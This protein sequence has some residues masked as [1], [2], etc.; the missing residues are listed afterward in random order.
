[1]HQKNI[2]LLAARLIQL[3]CKPMVSTQ[4]AAH[5]CFGM[6]QFD[7][8]HI[9]NFGEVCC[10]VL[11]HC[12]KGDEGKYDAVYYTALLKKR[13]AIPEELEVLDRQMAQIDW[14][15]IIAARMDGMGATLEEMVLAASFMDQLF[16]V[17]TNGILRYRYWNGTILESMIPDITIIK[18]QYELQQRF[19]LTPDQE[20]IRFEE[21]YRFLQ[22]RWMEKRILTERKLLLKKERHSDSAGSSKKLLVKR[23][24][25]HRT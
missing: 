7:L 14:P 23:K 21:A 2:E 20:P 19:Y 22:S 5:A 8:T 15:K 11:I 6:P 3:G 4:L 9:E 18:S 10:H 25:S 1:M 12:C 16:E 13:P 24:I 17:D